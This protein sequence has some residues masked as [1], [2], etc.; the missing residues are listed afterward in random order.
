MSKSPATSLVLPARSPEAPAAAIRAFQH[1]LL[2]VLPTETVYG[3]ACNAASPPAVERLAALS[4]GSKPSAWHAPSVDAVRAAINF[5]SPIHQRL[6]AKLLPGPVTLIVE[7]QEPD[8]AA[9]RQRL[10]VPAGALDDGR[11]I[12]VRVP[13]HSVAAAILD[14]ALEAGM[15]VVAQS[16]STAGWGDGRSLPDRHPWADT[17]GA[18]LDDGPA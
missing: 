15:P 14:Q 13:D 10:N 16:I 8:L 7:S 12:S 17:V 5:T 1:G 11:T 18:M 6:V 2:V 4:K 9:I 3:L